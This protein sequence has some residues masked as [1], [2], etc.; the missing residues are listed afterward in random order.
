SHGPYTP[1]PQVADGNAAPEPPAVSIAE[2]EDWLKHGANRNQELNNATIAGDVA[3]I[4]YLLGHGANVN[5]RDAQGYTPLQN[6]VRIG[7]PRL[8]SYLL[9]RKADPNLADHDRW[10]PLM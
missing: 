1:H 2:L 6:A 10:T 7:N 4:D 3:R 9:D 8:V 5:A